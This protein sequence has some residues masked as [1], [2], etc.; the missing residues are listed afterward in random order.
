MTEAKDSP[1]P[2]TKLREPLISGKAAADAPEAS[3]PPAPPS[4]ISFK[5]A[6][7]A[8]Q[9]LKLELDEAKVGVRDGAWLCAHAAEDGLY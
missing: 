2:S 5:A 9:W 4:H 6:A 7:H 1:C 3:L 8:I